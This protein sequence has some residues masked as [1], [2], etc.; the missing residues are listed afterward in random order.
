MYKNLLFLLTL[1]I[2]SFSINSQVI[3]TDIKKYK[4][5][6]EA[7]IY[8]IQSNNEELDNYIE[9]I[10]KGIWTINKYEMISESEVKTKPSDD[11]FY[12][13][14]FTSSFSRESSG[15][16]G[17]DMEY[18]V[19]NLFLFKAL[20]EEGKEGR[21]PIERL[22][23]IELSEFSASEI[24][25]SIQML[26][27]QIKLVKELNLESDLSFKKLLEK[28]KEQ[29][30]DVIKAKTLYVTESQMDRGLKN[31]EKIK[32][33][34]N[35]SVKI[36]SKEE[37]EEAILNRD[38]DIVYG[39]FMRLRTLH[40]LIIINADNSELLYGLVSTGF[41]QNKINRRFLKDLNK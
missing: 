31:I 2:Y 38:P 9:S 34:Y 30:Q 40:F 22:A 5:I 21:K 19:T 25:Y 37:I 8:F 15:S 6:D 4:N 10:L 13:N 11:S 29:K 26:Q 41:T 18:S 1:L 27:S 24:F 17:L 23:T 28:V 20:S 32:K 39:K 14:F 33:Q 3:D 36:K 16:G 35:Y 12:I 7:T